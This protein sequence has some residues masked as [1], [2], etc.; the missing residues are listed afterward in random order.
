MYAVIR[1]YTV[2]PGGARQLADRVEREFLPIL[3][4]VPGFVNYMYMEGGQEF[5]RD[6]LATVSIFDNKAGAELSVQ[7][8]AKWVGDNL[9]AFEPSQPTIVAGEVLASAGVAKGAAYAP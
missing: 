1:R 2:K 3:K 7:T 5:G 9:G 6:V 4:S 8:A